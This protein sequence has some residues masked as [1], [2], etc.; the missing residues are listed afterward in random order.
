MNMWKCKII[1]NS[2]IYLRSYVVAYAGLFKKNYLM[3]YQI[4]NVWNE[5]LHQVEFHKLNKEIKD[6][7][8]PTCDLRVVDTVLHKTLT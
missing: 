7:N 2:T 1:F 8:C 3:Q 6:V 4:S 5:T